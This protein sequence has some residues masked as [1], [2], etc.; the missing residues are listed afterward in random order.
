LKSRIIGFL[1]RQ[2]SAPF[3]STVLVKTKYSGIDSPHNYGQVLQSG[4][5]DTALLL[6]KYKR[7]S[8]IKFIILLLLEEAFV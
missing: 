6:V 1:L 7:V 5:V 2:A 3:L 4:Y 8:L